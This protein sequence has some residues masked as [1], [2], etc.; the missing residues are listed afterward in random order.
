[1][2]YGVDTRLNANQPFVAPTTADDLSATGDAAVIWDILRPMTIVRIG[3]L[4]STA[5]VSTGGVVIPFD[6]RILTGSDTGRV[7]AGIGT[8]T[9]PAGT[10]AGKVVYKDITPVDVNVGDQIVPEVT[11]A[12]T[13]SGA[14]RYFF[15]GRDRH[16]TPANQSDMIASA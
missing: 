15:E 14:A 4:V 11:T 7:D 13:S 5:V 16:E 3:A 10:A 8:I 12:A 6:R 2:P 9:I 1:M